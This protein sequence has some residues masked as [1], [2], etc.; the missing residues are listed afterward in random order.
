MH[1]GRK[2]HVGAASLAVSLLIVLAG[3]GQKDTAQAAGPPPAP[4]VAGKVEQRDI[5]VQLNAI[6]NVESYQT[7]QIRSQVNGQIVSVHFK[8]GQ[9]V[10]KGQLLFTLDKR[11]FQ[12]ALDQAVGNL[13]RDQAQA[14]NAEA[15]AKRYTELE[16]QGVVAREQAD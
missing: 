9:D 1:L 7:V 5:P 6:G 3:C 4:V 10:T 16:Q 13:R 11:P 14:T 12:A 15:Q 2:M 8:E